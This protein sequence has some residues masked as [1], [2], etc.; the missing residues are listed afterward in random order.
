MVVV[1]AVVVVVVCRRGRHREESLF[2]GFFFF[3][4]LVLLGRVMFLAVTGGG[5][6]R[7]RR[8][9]LLMLTGVLLVPGLSFLD[10]LLLGGDH[11][12]PHVVVAAPE[13]LAGRVALD[14]LLEHALVLGVAGVDVPHRLP[15][16]LGVAGVADLEG[17][18]GDQHAQREELGV[19]AGLHDLLRAREVL[20]A[21]DHGEGD[22]H[23]GDPR[24]GD[25]LV[26]LAPAKVH[27]AL[28]EGLVGPLGLLALGPPRVELDVDRVRVPLVRPAV[29]VGVD[30]A[31]ERARGGDEEGLEREREVAEKVVAA[32]GEQHAHRAHGQTDGAADGAALERLAVVFLFLFFCEEL[33]DGWR[34]L[35][36]GLQV[37]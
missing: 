18:G 6:R 36:C 4:F 31:G 32:L 13:A 20:V 34:R 2:L 29:G 11:L 27:G 33:H 16:A 9:L 1:V 8:R 14:L 37:R 24:A 10:P 26:A 35:G 5:G 7:R 17:G 15:A 25:D 12:L 23:A 3:L 19:H 30:D 21:V 28:G 22:A